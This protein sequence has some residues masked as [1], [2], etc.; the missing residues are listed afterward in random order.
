MKVKLYGNMAEKLFGRKVTSNHIDVSP[1]IFILKSLLHIFIA[2]WKWLS[3]WNGHV[4][5]SKTQEKSNFSFWCWKLSEPIS[6]MIVINSYW[7]K[8]GWKFPLLHIYSDGYHKKLLINSIK[9]SADML[10]SM[11]FILVWFDEIFSPWVLNPVDG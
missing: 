9:P 1:K 5:P 2:H 3:F 4:T 11:E 7:Q 6:P 8:I 10:K